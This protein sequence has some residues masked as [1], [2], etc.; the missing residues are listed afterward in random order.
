MRFLKPYVNVA[1][2]A[3][4]FKMFEAVLELFVPLVMKEII[5]IGIENNDRAFILQHGLI[6]VGLA[7]A[8]LIMSV[9]AQFFAAKTAVGFSKD[10]KS[11]LFRH[12]QTLSFSELD[13]VGT[14]TLINRMTA[15]ADKLQTGINM[16]LRLFLRSPFIVFGA[17]I[18]AFTIDRKSA[19]FFCVAIPLLSVVVFG[20]MLGTVPL[21]KK[22]QSALDRSLLTV[23]ENLDGIRVIRAFNMQK[24][25]EKR[26]KGETEDYASKA[27]FSSKVSS[28]LNPITFVIVNAALI[29]ILYNGSVEVNT[30][31]LTKG[32]L[33]AIV[34]YMSQILVELI[35]LA[36][37]IILLTKSLASANRISEVFEIGEKR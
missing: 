24:K 19:L 26:F 14:A 10:L 29:V 13:T 17:A 33:I 30:G 18:M 36:D 20:I 5:D 6:L 25:E 12:I 31:D 4:L 32:E 37:L 9:T 7:A 35:K 27:I 34:N 11:S 15:D 28:L 8:G 3:P 16:T 22:V 23:G 1:I 21:Y 2:P